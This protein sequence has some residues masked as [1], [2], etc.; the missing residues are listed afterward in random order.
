[1]VSQQICVAFVCAIC[2]QVC[3]D[4][5]VQRFGLQIEEGDEKF[6]QSSEGWWEVQ[7]CNFGTDRT[8]LVNGEQP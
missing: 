8:D 6:S 5:R 3:Q 2:A 1:M 7:S 4:L